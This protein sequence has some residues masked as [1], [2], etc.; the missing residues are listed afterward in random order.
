M[1][2]EFFT[3]PWMEGFFGDQTQKYYYSHLASALTFIPYGTMVDEYQHRIYEKPGMSA[4]ERND[5]WLQLEGKYRPWLNLEGFPF[6][7]EGRRWQAQIHIYGM[8]FY[9]IDYCI[10]QVMALSFWAEDQK[11]HAAAWAKYRR[12]VGFAGAKTFVE[13]VND[14]GLPSPFVPDNLKAVADAAVEWLDKQ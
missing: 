14:A 10:A 4:K 8:P 1:A 13:L 11:D 12:L 5:L 3:W 7:G 2:M 6:Y 9:Y